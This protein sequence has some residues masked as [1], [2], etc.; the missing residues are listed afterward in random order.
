MQ[1]VIVDGEQETG[2]EREEGGR[3]RERDDKE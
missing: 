1:V 2:D 3:K